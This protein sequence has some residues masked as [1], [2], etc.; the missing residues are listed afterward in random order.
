VA[1]EKSS[2][3]LDTTGKTPLNLISGSEFKINDSSMSIKGNRSNA[4]YM[5]YIDPSSKFVSYNSSVTL[6][7]RATWGVFD[8]GLLQLNGSSLIPSVY[9]SYLVG[10]YDGGRIHA[11]SSNIGS[12]GRKNIYGVVMESVNYASGSQTNVYSASLCLTGTAYNGFKKIPDSISNS[13]S[14]SCR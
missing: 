9:A 1:T 5:I 14:W 6:D 13:Y 10:V 7:S 12:T 8:Q 11:D 4:D 2:I 3:S